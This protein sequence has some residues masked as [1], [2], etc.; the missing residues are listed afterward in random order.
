[1]S[2]AEITIKRDFFMQ[3]GTK[4]GEEGYF[5][6]SWDGNKHKKKRFKGDQ[7]SKNKLCTAKVGQNAIFQGSRK[8]KGRSSRYI[9]CV[10]AE[11]AINPPNKVVG[12]SYNKS[13]NKKF[14]TK[15]GFFPM[16]GKIP[17]IYDERGLL[18]PFADP[19]KTQ[20]DLKTNELKC[21]YTSLDG[22]KIRKIE[23]ASDN[24]QS[25]GIYT[26]LV[27][28]FC[29]DTKYASVVVNSDK[30][31][32]NDLYGDG[33]PKDPNAPNDGKSAS[34][35]SPAP[36]PEPERKRRTR[37]VVEEEEDSIWGACSIQ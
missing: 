7:E 9:D 35:E 4:E 21:V 14:R 25:K 26:E 2:D 28:G 31:T 18:C 34:S 24:K 12:E 22:E 27:E 17:G 10:V 1:M 19:T 6:R 3:P 15:D 33:A 29:K 8:K 30:K 5:V 16:E 20:F 23:L 32:C 36:A 11:H 13:K 37:R